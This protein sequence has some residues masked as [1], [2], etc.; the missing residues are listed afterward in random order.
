MSVENCFSDFFV[1]VDESGDHGMVSIDPQF[2]VF[3]L[4]FVIIKKIDYIQKILPAF[5]DLKLKYWGHDQVVFHESDIRKE[6]GVFDILRQG[7][8]RSFFMD[9]LTNLIDQSPFQ[10]ISSVI[11]KSDL[12]DRYIHP[13]NPYE[14][15]LLFCMERLLDVLITHNQ[16][17]KTCHILIEARGKKEDRALELEFRRICDNQ[18]KLNHISKKDFKQ[19]GFE[20]VI[21]DKKSNRTSDCLK[22]FEARSN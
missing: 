1:F 14:L 18:G 6:R 2:P 19:A 16:K 3:A 10:S 9:D 21:V 8:V 15:G 20:M 11:K 17:E 13:H 12:S 4:V 7:E 5:H 22:R